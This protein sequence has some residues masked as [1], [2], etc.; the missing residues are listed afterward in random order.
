MTQ[1]RYNELNE[2]YK[3]LPDTDEAFDEWRESL[4]KEYDEW[5]DLDVELENYIDLKIFEYHV[6][7]IM[8]LAT[9]YGFDAKKIDPL[10]KDDDFLRFT[11]TIFIAGSL[12]IKPEEY[13]QREGWIAEF[14]ETK[15]EKK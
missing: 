9:I 15:G 1:E 6:N 3:K 5:N 12:H 2:E 13:H 14:F 7:T 8:G 10:L 11:H 4:G